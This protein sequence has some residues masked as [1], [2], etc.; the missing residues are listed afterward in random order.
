MTRAEHPRTSLDNWLVVRPKPGLRLRSLRESYQ[1]SEAAG[2]R[3]KAPD[4]GIKIAVLE[5]VH[6]HRI[7]ELPQGLVPHLPVLSVRI[8]QQRVPEALY[9]DSRIHRHQLSHGYLLAIQKDNGTD[10]RLFRR[11]KS[12]FG[13]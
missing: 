9:R 8:V 13:G 12:Q 5:L 10:D 4:G 3:V 1:R 6:C 11:D 7:C 2:E